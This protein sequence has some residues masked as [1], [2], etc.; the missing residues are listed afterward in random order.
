MVIGG[1]AYTASYLLLFKAFYGI[2]ISMSNSS[3]INF[4]R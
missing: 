2:M 1:S 4:M 3:N